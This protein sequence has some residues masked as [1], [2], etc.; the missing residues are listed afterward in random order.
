MQDSSEQRFINA[1]SV[2]AENSRLARPV[3]KTRQIQAAAVIVL[4][5]L[6]FALA[7]AAIS[8]SLQ[9]W[10][11][12][13]LPNVV[14]MSQVDAEKVLSEQG[15][16]VVV[17]VKASD[18][19]KG[20]VIEMQPSFDT[21]VPDG[22]S[23]TI[24]VANPRII[25]E[26]IGQSIEQALQRLNNEGFYNIEQIK[27]SSEQT[28]GTVLKISPA[29]GELAKA[30]TLISIEIASAFIVPDVV[31]MQ[32]P[33]AIKAIKDAGL[34]PKIE[35]EVN[36]DVEEGIV[37]E[38]RPQAG[39]ELSHNESVEVVVA[40]H[41]SDEYISFAKHYLSSLTDFKFNGKSYELVKVQHVSFKEGSTCEYKIDARTFENQDWSQDNPKRRYGPSVTLNG[42]IK[43][44][45]NGNIVFT[46]PK[47]ES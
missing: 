47:I 18:E 40:K 44:D 41:K 26:V 2:N 4:S 42:E 17:E 28:A 11:G 36:E 45:S 21:R 27:V 20:Y 5:I 14:G 6:V 29:S 37:L 9:L 38:T 43:F 30:D 10:G 13:L 31:G 3:T 23:V 7:I 33:L 35:I 8:Y 1:S 32:E 25:P 39:S 34:A 15:Y 46:N 16:K 19:Q 12:K 22:S 24:Y